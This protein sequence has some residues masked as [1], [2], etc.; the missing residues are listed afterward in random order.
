M[1]RV[2]RSTEALLSWAAKS[3]FV[4]LNLPASQQFDILTLAR[5][6][7]GANPIISIYIEGD[8]A[9]WLSSFT[10]PPDPTPIRPLA[11]GL[12]ITQPT[13]SAIYLARPCQYLASSRC[14]PAYWT[15]RRFSEEIIATY[16]SLLNHLQEK[17]PKSRWR[18]IGYSGGG[19]IALALQ[20]RRQD[21]KQVITVAS[22]VDLDAWTQFHGLSQIE[23]PAYSPMG[24]AQTIRSLHHLA[25]GKDRV[26]PISVAKAGAARYG[27]QLF[28][29][30]DF[31]HECCWLGIWGI[32][33]KTIIAEE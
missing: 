11:L 20:A 5:I 18:L 15:N 4:R 33:W 17:F 25:G 16:D 9:P 24:T 14:E 21:I 6:Q 7:P 29:F 8:G 32:H 26:L 10:P 28:E 1:P 3:N 30:P 27:G 19:V 12:A 31:D 2:G 23:K 22:P 13:G